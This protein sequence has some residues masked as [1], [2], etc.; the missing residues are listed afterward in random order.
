MPKANLVGYVVIDGVA[1]N[2]TINQ[3]TLLFS[4]MQDVASILTVHLLMFQLIS[5]ANAKPHARQILTRVAR[6]PLFFPGTTT[7]SSSM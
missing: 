1:I 3:S 5:V 2:Q 6:L 7:T 4:C